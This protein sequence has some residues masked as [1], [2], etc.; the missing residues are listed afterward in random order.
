MKQLIDRGTVDDPQT[1]DSLYWGAAKI[2][3]NAT[4]LYDKDTAQ[5]VIIDLN[6]T[7]RT[8][9]GSDHSFIDQDVTQSAT[10]TFEKI[11]I[12]T[13]PATNKLSVAGLSGGATT[14]HPI[15]FN[16]SIITLGYIGA[17]VSN[18]NSGAIHLYQNGVA[19]TVIS[20]AG[21]SYLMGG[22][23]GFGVVDAKSQIHSSAGIQM[24]DD[25]DVA[26]ADKEGTLKY[27]KDANNSYVDQCMQTGAITYAWVNIKTNSW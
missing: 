15:K 27:Y 2:N 6:T 7:H 13:P 1:G 25:T 24:G 19:N 5:D 4:E 22:K 10:P 20:A 9:D 12:N 26:S 14:D 23:A 3:E 21:K 17:D 11:G 8:S 18:Y 16:N